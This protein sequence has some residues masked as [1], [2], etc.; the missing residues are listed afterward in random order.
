VPSSITPNRLHPFCRI[1]RTRFVATEHPFCRITHCYLRDYHRFLPVRIYELKEK[2]NFSAVDNSPSPHWNPQG[3]RA[4]SVSPASQEEAERPNWAHSAARLKR[5]RNHVTMLGR[6]KRWVLAMLA[7]AARGSV[8][9][10]YIGAFDPP[11]AWRASGSVGT[12]GVPEFLPNASGAG[13]TK[14]YFAGLH[15]RRLPTPPGLRC[16]QGKGKEVAKGRWA[17]PRSHKPERAQYG[18]RRRF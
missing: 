4:L 2:L 18:L 1:A 10:D 7:N 13:R 8:P 12:K 5:G 14:G 17:Y 11:C 16:A 6:V 3:H 9:P 15:L